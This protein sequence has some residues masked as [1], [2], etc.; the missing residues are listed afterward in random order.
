MISVD[1]LAILFLLTIIL[2]G[3]CLLILHKVRRIHLMQY[4]L[5]QQLEQNLPEHLHHTYQQIQAFIDLN[6]LLQL[7]YPLPPLRGWA[8]S[9]DFLLFL[10]EHILQKKP[11]F[12]VE[13]SSGAS[14][15]VLAQCAKLNGYGHVLSLEHD[16][17]YANKTRQQLIKQGLEDWATVIDAPLINYEFNG[18]NYQWYKLNAQIENTCI[19][20]LVIDGPPANL[21]HC[22]RYP[23]GPLLLPLLNTEGVVFLDDADRPDEKEIVQR[24]VVEFTGFV[25]QKYD[26]EKGMVGLIRGAMG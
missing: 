11:K 26:C 13:C 3:L 17:H 1:P 15:V 10:A 22:A 20:M 24:W 9:P 5:R 6:R 23:A 8:A 25:Y 14:T 12:I 2:F 16:A 7:T 19:D 18:Q 4:A 21:N